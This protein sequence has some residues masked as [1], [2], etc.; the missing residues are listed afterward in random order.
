ML[1]LAVNGDSE[2]LKELK[3]VRMII[4]GEIDGLLPSRNCL[5]EISKVAEVLKPALERISKAVETFRLGRVIIW[6]KPDSLLLSS[7]CLIDISKVAKSSKPT[8]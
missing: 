2:V 5:I 3:F 6:G 1:R 4:W 7:D 8:I